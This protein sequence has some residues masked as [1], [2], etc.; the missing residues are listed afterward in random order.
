M[1]QITYIFELTIKLGIKKLKCIA[2]LKEKILFDLVLF[3][4][5]FF[6]SIFEIILA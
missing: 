3:K 5:D 1:Q 6:S 4:K 2:L